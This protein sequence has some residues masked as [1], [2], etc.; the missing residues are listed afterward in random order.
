LG[1]SINLLT[2]LALVLAIG[3]VVDDA[4]IVVENIDRHLKEGATPFSAAIQGARELGGP[5]L[6]M[7]VVLVAAYAPIAF[8]SGLTGA[9]FTQFAFTLVGAITV[10]AVVALT[11]SPMMCS[12]IFRAEME[13]GRFAR[14]VDR[15]FSRLRSGYQRMLTGWLETW[16][17]LI[18]LLVL[19]LASLPYLFMTSTSEL[20]P[21]EDQGFVAYQLIGP[22]DAT[23]AQMETYSRQALAAGQSLPEYR[24]AFQVVGAPSVTQGIGGIL[25]KPWSDRSRSANQLQQILQKKWN[26]IAGAEVA[27]FQFPPLP[28][29]QGLPVQFVIT[30][31]EPI[32]N[33]Y[34]VEQQVLSRAKA[35][36]LFWFI[37]GDLKIDA[38]QQTIV[39][40]HDMVAQLGL[41]EQ[42]VASVLGAAMGGGYVNY[43]TLAGRSYKVIPQVLQKYRLN[44]QQV[45]NLHLRAANGSLV[46]LGTIAHLQRQTV[47]ESI[48]H[49]QQVNSATIAGAPAVAQGAALAFLRKTLAEVA[50]SGYTVDYSGAS[51][52]YVEGS[53]GFL[54]TFGFALI[55]VFL[56]LAA[57][58]ESFRDPIVI[59]VSVPA[60]L[61]G[62]LLFINFGVTSLNI[63]SQVGLVTLLGLI[64]KHGILMVQFANDEQR[65][66]KPKRAAIIEAAAVRL[67]PILMTTAAMVLGVVPL[68]FASG[69]G[70]AGRKAMG[71]VIFT[72]LSIG[73]IFT[74]FIVPAVYLLLAADHEKKRQELAEPTMSS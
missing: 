16:Q 3:L 6:A 15:W 13:E 62:A 36:G 31:S 20:A 46:Q 61:F 66:G 17:V 57:L 10:S 5:I 2:L 14:L 69:A 44:P 7:T 71:W 74:L 8:Q 34:R 4:I 21:Q 24:G 72:G 11:L 55:I 50:P 19:L 58:F 51:R 29:A 42:Q 1:Y 23:F 45:L 35:S 47:P 12:R 26:T 30:T 41:T 38:P 52:Q 56:S 25:F 9:L 40:N 33:L 49:F 18:V 65:A 43:F 63:Y 59:L 27:A 53:N 73:T 22:P 70:A 60:A 68:V 54:Y 64:S 28:G 67:R 32:E 37:D 48:N 39:V